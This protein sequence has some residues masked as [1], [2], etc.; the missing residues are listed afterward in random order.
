MDTA[1]R[2]YPPSD[3]RVSD[4]ERDRAIAELSEHF[5]AGRITSEEFDERSTQALN[6]KTGN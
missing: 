5:Q 6:A 1:M 4:A 3:L 2:R